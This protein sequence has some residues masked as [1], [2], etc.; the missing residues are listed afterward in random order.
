MTAATVALSEIQ[1]GLTPKGQELL[2]VFVIGAVVDVMFTHYS[3]AFLKPDILPSAAAEMDRK[4]VSGTRIP[5]RQERVRTL[6]GR[7]DPPGNIIVPP[8]VARLQK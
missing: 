1:T 6:A 5:R 7:L 8:R 3:D 4:N 2:G